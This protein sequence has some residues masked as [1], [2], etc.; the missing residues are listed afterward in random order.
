[1]L[2][3]LVPR[4]HQAFRHLQYGKQWKAG[5]GLACSTASDR[6]LGRAWEWGYMLRSSTA[7]DAFQSM[8]TKHHELHREVGDGYISC[9]L[10]LGKKEPF[11]V[12]HMYSY[13]SS[14]HRCSLCNQ[15]VDISS[16]NRAQPAGSPSAHI[17]LH[18]ST[19]WT[20]CAKWAQEFH[21]QATDSGSHWPGN[22][23]KTVVS[24]ECRGLD[25]NNEYATVN[26]IHYK[27]S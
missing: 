14:S 9:V 18:P 27:E 3:S 4:P 13:L 23:P 15:W 22:I 24:F 16:H 11:H 19:T 7:Q 6:K 5:R 2:R 20:F 21:S 1:M 17:P 26:L 25:T 12:L 8:C 10:I